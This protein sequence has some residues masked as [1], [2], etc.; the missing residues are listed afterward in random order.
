VTI[1]AAL[2]T[3]VILVIIDY[4]RSRH[5]TRSKACTGATASPLQA[6]AAVLSVKAHPSGG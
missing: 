3:F 4:V 6:E 2:A 1:L 5:S